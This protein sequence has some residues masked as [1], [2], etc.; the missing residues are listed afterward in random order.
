LRVKRRVG[1]GFGSLVVA[2]IDDESCLGI[3]GRCVVTDVCTIV[4]VARTSPL[5]LFAGQGRGAGL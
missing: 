4:V 5:P 3:Q 1:T 2:C